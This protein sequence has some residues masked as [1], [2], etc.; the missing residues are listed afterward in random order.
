[1]IWSKD[2]LHLWNLL[3]MLEIIKH[4]TTRALLCFGALESSSSSRSWVG[5]SQS[6]SASELALR[7]PAIRTL[8]GIGLPC[9]LGV[10][11]PPRSLWPLAGKTWLGPTCLA[12]IRRRCCPRVTT[13]DGSNGLAYPVAL[14]LKLGMFT[15]GIDPL[16]AMDPSAA[17]SSNP[18]SD[19]CDGKGWVLQLRNVS[20]LSRLPNLSSDLYWNTNIKTV[21][22][23]RAAQHR[24]SVCSSHPAVPGSNLP[25]PKIFT[26][27]V[28]EIYL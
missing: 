5:G 14:L 13:P 21:R 18:A 4:L 9:G 1:M 23:W 11:V 20:S 24:G 26:I 6:S 22:T 15:A 3:M 10:R 28:A 25:V 16:G 17:S 2:L 19:P 8:R 7:F 12:P 27:D